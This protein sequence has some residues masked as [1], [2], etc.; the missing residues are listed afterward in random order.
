MACRN[1]CNHRVRRSCYTSPAT[2]GSAVSMTILI[3]IIAVLFSHLPPPSEPSAAWQTS[4][5][6]ALPS[7]TRQLGERKSEKEEA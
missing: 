2:P 5:A 3:V 7:S 4:T 1:H 6:A